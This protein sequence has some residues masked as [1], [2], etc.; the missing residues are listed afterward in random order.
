MRAVAA[1]CVLIGALLVALGGTL[2]GVEVAIIS[3]AGGFVA[4]CGLFAI[5]IDRGDE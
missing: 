5:D 4:A 3:G 2:W 1:L